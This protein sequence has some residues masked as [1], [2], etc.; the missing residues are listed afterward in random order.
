M[1]DNAVLDIAVAGDGVA[2]IVAAH[3]LGR[4]HK[5]TLYEKND[6]I[7]GHTR[8]V[9]V[10]E[11]NGGTVSVDTGFIVF[12]DRTYPNFIRFIQQLGVER[13]ESPMSFTYWNR[14]T[15]FLYNTTHPFADRKNLLNPSF[16]RLLLEIDRFN[17]KTRRLLSQNRLGGMT[18]GR[19][20]KSSGFSGALASF[21]VAPICS[22]IWS[23]GE[24]S[25]LGFPAETFG[26]FF[27][28]HGLLS[29]FN[30]PRWY[31]VRGGSREYVKAFLKTFSGTVRPN[32]PVRKIRR[33][34]DRVRLWTDSGEA[35]HDKVVIAAHADEAL[36]M[37]ADP[38]DAE[39]RLLAPWRYTKNRVVLHRD[40]S[41]L[42]VPDAARGSWNYTRGEDGPGPGAFTKNPPEPSPEVATL[43][44]YMNRLQ[45]LKT[46]AH[47][48]VSLNPGHFPAEDLMISDHR[49][50]HPLY[51]E[52]AVATQK[53]LGA[54]NG[55]NNTWF[56]GSYFRY[57]FHEDAVMSAAAVG[58]D[59][60]IGL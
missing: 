49:F 24:R 14:Q 60:G 3:L 22:A 25:M 18:L 7:G 32:C 54:L 23:A 47:Y 20:L 46:D 38:S 11:D 5:V 50:D 17:R 6:Y 36:A 52:A 26:R 53:H 27:E 41:F 4:R 42:P 10:P 9:A 33:D 40:T 56:C 39:Y 21:Y 1:A 34:R 35:V 31:T 15:G 44:Y 28:N 48:C 16:W 57:G 30:Q 51:T 29:Y 13:H 12:N 45:Q 2:G 59:F 55:V 8:T 19:Y 43:T 37:L 58:E